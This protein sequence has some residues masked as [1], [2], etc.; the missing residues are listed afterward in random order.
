MTVSDKTFSA[1]PPNSDAAVSGSGVNGAT[2]SNLS[3]DGYSYLVK[4]G[5]GAQSYNINAKDLTCTANSQGIF[6]ANVSN[7]T[8]TNLNLNAQNPAWGGKPHAIYIERGNHDLTFTNV[9]VTASQAPAGQA[10]HL[11]A[12]TISSDPTDNITFD[13]LTVG[14]PT[15]PVRA[16]IVANGYSHI[17][18]RNL[19]AYSVTDDPVIAVY[20]GADSI[21]VDGFEC[22]GGSALV[23]QTGGSGSATN[24]VV[25]NG[26][27]HGSTLSSGVTVTQNNVTLAP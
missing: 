17:T 14:S 8:F 2:I 21:T 10:I 18:F 12:D 25:E 7:S 15:Q 22:W 20:G 13:G 11:Y 9:M 6:L 3:S 1:T 5:S 4:I 26:T 27:Y 24:I 16:I 23:A 19:T